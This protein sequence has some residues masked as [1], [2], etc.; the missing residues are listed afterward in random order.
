MT[1]QLPKL[2]INKFRQV[3]DLPLVETFGPREVADGGKLVLEVRQGAKP[4]YVIRTTFQVYGWTTSPDLAFQA[5]GNICAYNCN[6]IYEAFRG[7]KV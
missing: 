2:N 7:R 1:T 6:E 3:I 5:W 4:H